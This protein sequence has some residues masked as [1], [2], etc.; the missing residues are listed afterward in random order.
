[1]NKEEQKHIV[2]NYPEISFINESM[3]NHSTFGVGGCAKIFLLPKKESEVVKILENSLNNQKSIL[4][5][6]GAGNI[7]SLSS[8]LYM[9]FK[10]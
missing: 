2:N 6:Q 3:K 7:S 1:M 8:S 10:K 5:I 9:R 4:L